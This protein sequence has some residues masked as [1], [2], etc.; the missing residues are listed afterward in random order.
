MTSF[1]A[2]TCRPAAGLIAA[3]V[4]LFSNQLRTLHA[5]SLLSVLS[6]VTIVIAVALCVWKISTVQDEAATAVTSGAGGVGAPVAVVHELVRS[7]SSFWDVF[8]A[9]SSFVFAMSGQK[10]YLE[11]MAEMRQPAD[12]PKVT[13]D[14]DGIVYVL[15]MH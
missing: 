8:S 5:I 4:L 10:I 1:S 9:I 7:D 6:G 14:R 2:D 12:F 11:M 15:Y 13:S 3:F